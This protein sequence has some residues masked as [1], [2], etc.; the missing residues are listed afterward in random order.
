[1]RGV[2]VRGR[3]GC[4]RPATP[5][6]DCYAGLAWLAAHT[7]ELGI[8]PTIRVILGLQHVVR[9]ARGVQQFQLQV[10]DDVLSP[11]GPSPT[12]PAISRC[13]PGPGQSARACGFVREEPG[14]SPDNHA[15]SG[16]GGQAFCGK[17][18]SIPPWLGSSHRLVMALPRVKKCT[19]SV[20][21]AWLSPNREAFQP[22]KL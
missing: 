6:E 16:P 22:P 1:M 10:R 19:P 21:W 17:P 15:R 13:R 14:V 8:D 12:M 11:S 9:V 4:R 3:G 5:V 7:G 20:P 18:S 2:G